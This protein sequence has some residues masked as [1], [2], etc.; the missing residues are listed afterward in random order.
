RYVKHASLV[1]NCYPVRPDEKGPKSSDLSYLVYYTTAKPAKLTKVGSYI[2]RRVL[3]DFRKKRL[4]DVHCSL[5]IIRTLVL[6]S[7]AHLNIFSKNVIV[8]LDAILVDISDFDIVRHCQTVF[9]CFASAYDG[10]TLGVD[11]EFRTLYERVISRFASIATHS[12]D[13]S[14]RAQLN[15]VLPPIL[16]CLIDSKTGIPQPL[17]REPASASSGPSPRPS[18]STDREALVTDR[19]VIDEALRCLHTLFCSPNGGY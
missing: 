14:D 7:K 3:R 8:I 6:S 12:G 19:D 10:S 5:E 1:N 9:S 17:F 15:M 2:E 16:D 13:D 11:P 4:S 18:M